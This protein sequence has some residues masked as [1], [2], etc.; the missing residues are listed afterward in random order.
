MSEVQQYVNHLKARILDTQDSAH[1][2]DKTL[3]GIYEMAGVSNAEELSVV[4]QEVFKEAE[5]KTVIEPK[6]KKK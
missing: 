6:G 3:T 1:A 2:L 4:L 5:P